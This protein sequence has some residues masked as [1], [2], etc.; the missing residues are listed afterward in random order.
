VTGLAHDETG[1]P[2][3]DPVRIDKLMRRLDD[4]LRRHRADIVEVELS[5]V[6]GAELLVFAYGSVARAARQAVR[7]AREQGIKVGLFRPRTIWPFP[8]EELRKAADGIPKIL[9]PEL[10]LGQ[11]AHEVEWCVGRDCRVER[12]G[13]VDGLPIRPAQIL[14][15]IQQEAPVQAVAP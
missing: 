2:T 14:E 9:V 13:R 4:K 12:L 11:L 3:N 15:H 7:E 10:N 6:E 5:D 1:F 8:D